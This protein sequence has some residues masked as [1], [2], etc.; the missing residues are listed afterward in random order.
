MVFRDVS[1]ARAIELKL[2]HLAQHDG[3]TELPNRTLLTD[4]L[5]HSIALAERH[6]RQLAVLF[7]DLD[8]LKQ[9]NDSLG[10]AI[11]DKV[12]RA[13][14]KRLMAVV[15]G[16]DTVGRLGG[17]EFVVVLSE[18]ENAQNAA[19]HAERIHA[20]LTESIAIAE[21]DLQITIVSESASFLSY[22]L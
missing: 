18:V 4:R 20:A 1:E 15:R 16:S 13:V 2:S 21:H 17:D 10:H 11:G 5:S 14:A 9:I 22:D 3:L 6:K 7:I 8:R 12:L 19:R